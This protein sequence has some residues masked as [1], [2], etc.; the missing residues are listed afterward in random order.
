MTCSHYSM[1]F[2]ISLRDMQLKSG[3]SWYA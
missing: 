3:R 2:G 1:P